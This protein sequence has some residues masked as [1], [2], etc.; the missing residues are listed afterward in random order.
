MKLGTIVK[1]SFVL[2]FIIVSIAAWLKI[3][4]SQISETFLIIGIISTSIFIATAIYEIRTSERI[5]NAEKTIWTF[6][7]IFFTAITALI[8]FLVGRKRIAR[9]SLM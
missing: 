4:H 2:S 3:I 8:Y 9:Y 6:A 1:S 7:F 5:G